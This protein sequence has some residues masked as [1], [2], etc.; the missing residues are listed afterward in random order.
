VCFGSHRVPLHQSRRPPAGT[1]TVVLGIR[2][3]AFEEATF[4]PA[5]L[6]TLEA[7]VT[8]LEELGAD[9]YVFFQVDGA[10]VGGGAAAEDDDGEPLADGGSLF[11]ARV[12]PRATVRV[13]DSVRLA[14]DPARF[15]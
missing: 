7:T 11:T 10:P 8:V 9:A 14:V 1:G 6:P 13:G 3:E 15:H 2:P 5:G 4:A 12:D